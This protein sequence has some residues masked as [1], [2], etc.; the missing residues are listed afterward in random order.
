MIAFGFYWGSDT[1]L[2][3]TWNAL[4]FIIV[5]LSVVSEILEHLSGIDISFI[6]A[7]RAL[8]IL[9]AIKI[10][11][12]NEGL[13]GIVNSL[14]K[15]IPTLFNVLPVILMFLVTFGI[16]GI[17]F[18]KGKVSYCSDK[19]PSINTKSE[20]HG[21]FKRD[22]KDVHREW[23]TPFNNYDDIF[24]SMLTFFEVSFLELFP[25]IMFAAMDSRE[26]DMTPK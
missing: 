24:R 15:S 3:D 17:Q 13:K 10:I 26:E 11:K 9:R 16:L 14:L 1:Y 20:C 4:D 6:R 18:L 25:N 22:G 7:F 2:S 23:L 19:S 21:T 12:V 8:R 5:L